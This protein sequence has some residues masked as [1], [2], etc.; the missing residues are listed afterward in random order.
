MPQVEVD[1]MSLIYVRGF[2]GVRVLGSLP[3][4][5]SSR[6]RWEARFCADNF[7]TSVGELARP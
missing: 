1:R 2:M 3:T 7:R 5:T 4:T 6:M